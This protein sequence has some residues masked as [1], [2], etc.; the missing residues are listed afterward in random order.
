MT[1]NTNN[2]MH[3][4]AFSQPSG[5]PQSAHA[6]FQ[7]GFA[8]TN[9][10]EVQYL[11]HGG[12]PQASATP[13]YGAFSYGGS[14]GST[15]AQAMYQPGFAGTNSQE[16]R[17]LNHSYSNQPAGSYMQSQTAYQPSFGSHSIFSPGFAG[18]NVHEV[19]ARNSGTYTGY[20]GVSSYPQTSMS[21]QGQIYGGGAGSIFSPNFAGT[22]VQEVRQQNQASYSPAYTSS[23]YQQPQAQLQQ[24][25]YYAGYPQQAQ[26]TTASHLGMGAQATTASHLGM[27]MGAQAVYSPSF[28]GTNVQEVRALNAGQAAPHTGSIFPGSF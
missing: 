8:G 10:S 15:S 7:P 22:N 4:Q 20:S 17:H 28:A 25:S 13:T 14:T 6:V 18:T 1:Y 3:T 12:Q 11:N 19:Q 16:V 21:S 24:Q 2:I 9:A 5:F 26:A 23:F 27:G